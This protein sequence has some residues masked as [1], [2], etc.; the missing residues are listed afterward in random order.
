[1][2]FTAELNS[3]LNPSV[4]TLIS[5]I[6]T[7]VFGAHR[8]LCTHLILMILMVKL[9]G[10]NVTPILEVREKPRLRKVTFLK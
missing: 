6:R 4:A 3:A 7:T 1:M 5:I 2:E 10:D 8:E 9:Y